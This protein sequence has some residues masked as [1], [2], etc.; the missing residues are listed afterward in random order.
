MIVDK[1]ARGVA[2][3]VPV[4]PIKA[5]PATGLVSFTFDDIPR[6]AWH[7]GGEIL[8]RHGVEGT[9]YVA[10]GLTGGEDEASGNI[11]HT[12]DDLRAIAE[13]GHEIA[14]HG[15][16]HRPF[17]DLSKNE[18]LE[19]WDRNERYLQSLFPD[20]MISNL[21]YPLGMA[22]I[23]D[24][25]LA[26]KRFTSIRGVDPGLNKGLCDFSQLKSNGLYS[27]RITVEKVKALIDRAA[28]DKAWVI[29]HTHD[30]AED[31]TPWGAT[32]SLFEEAVKAAVDSSC[33]VMP[34]RNAIGAVAFTGSAEAA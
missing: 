5:R 31:P 6:S 8:A 7:M 24:K 28:R 19:D 33:R 1:V 10:G 17:T 18:L 26:A 14:S 12:E 32:P 13:E 9:Y 30:V 34:V 22:R 27:S 29:F 21:S 3:L 15:F 4:K 16:A 11:C 25:S 2:R 23:R 20:R